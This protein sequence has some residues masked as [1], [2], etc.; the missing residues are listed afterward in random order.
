MFL[1]TVTEQYLSPAT[2]ISTRKVA[3]E[4]VE[5]IMCWNLGLSLQNQCDLRY[6]PTRDNQVGRLRLESFYR[7][8]EMVEFF[9]NSLAIE[10][11][12][13]RTLRTHLSAESS[14]VGRIKGC[15]TSIC[16]AAIHCTRLSA[17]G[18]CQLALGSPSEDFLF[19]DRM[20]WKP[21]S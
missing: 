14:L 4:V 8:N 1:L 6:A 10:L 16:N 11:L 20:I 21:A 19:R 13:I 7:L 12:K 17:F 9:A 5:P 15:I 2:S 3:I 18:D